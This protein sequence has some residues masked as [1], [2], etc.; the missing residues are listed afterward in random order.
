MDAKY[1]KFPLLKFKPNPEFLVMAV[2]RPRVAGTNARKGVRAVE[3]KQIS[4][5]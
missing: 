2:Y 4:N 3:S 1:G 5:L